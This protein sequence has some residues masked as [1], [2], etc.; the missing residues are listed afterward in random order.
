MKNFMN[1]LTSTLICAG[2]GMMVTAGFVWVILL[3][4]NFKGF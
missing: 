1:K 3:A 2:L 4:S